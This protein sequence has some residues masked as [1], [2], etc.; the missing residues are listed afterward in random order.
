MDVIE[1]VKRPCQCRGFEC[2]GFDAEGTNYGHQIFT[3]N[4]LTAVAV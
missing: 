2:L 1:E 4:Y 3:S